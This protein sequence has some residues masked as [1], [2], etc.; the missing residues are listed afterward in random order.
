MRTHFALLIVLCLSFSFCYAEDGSA[1]TVLQMNH[2]IT[3][4]GGAIREGKYTGETVN[5]VPNGYGLFESKTPDGVEWH[6]IGQWVNGSMSGSGA[7]YW[8]NG[9]VEIGEY[10]NNDPQLVLLVPAN[11]SAIT[12]FD[13]SQNTLEETYV[14]VYDAKTFKVIF[15]GYM[16]NDSQAYTRGT[17]YNSSGKVLIEGIFGEGFSQSMMQSIFAIY[18]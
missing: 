7:A 18:W 17:I 5:N 1:Q 3:L 9:Q 13:K 10:E 6:Y 8:N 11:T 12:Y 4:S 2:S 14:R 16:N 15:D